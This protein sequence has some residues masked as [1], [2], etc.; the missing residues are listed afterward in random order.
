MAV[1]RQGR[2]PSASAIPALP[3]VLGL[4][5]VVLLTAAWWA[6]RDDGEPGRAATGPASTDRRPSTTRPTGP[7]T[8]RTS[9][10]PATT[11]SPS[12]TARPATTTTTAPAPPP[13]RG[14]VAERAVASWP[15]RRRLAS[16]LF[17]GVD[18]T[19]TADAGR[20]VTQEHVGGLFVG[21]TATGLLTSGSLRDLRRVAPAGLLVA[22]DEE[23]GRVQRIDRLRGDLPAARVLARTRSTAEVRALA[24]QRAKDL[25][26]YG[27]T[28]DFAPSVDT[29]DQP[30]RTVI[31][32]RSFSADPQVAARYGAAF[33]DGL[34]AAG[35]VPTIKHFPGHGRASGDSHETGVVTPPLDRMEPVD[36][37]PYRELIPGLGDRT[38]VMLGHLQVPGLTEPG[39]PASLSPA[40]VDLLRDEY[41]FTGVIVTDDLSGMKAVTGTWTPADAA[42][43]ALAA[44]VDMPLLGDADVPALLDR[45]ERDVRSGAIPEAQVNRAVV[46]VSRLKGVEPCSVRW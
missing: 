19:G 42:S 6:V 13:C 36:L 28:M 26:S 20:L 33:A 5:V 29:S 4:L 23:G 10:A 27:V 40:A 22:V 3:V 32:D 37:V 34:L 16:L 1:G 39:R 46:R 11:A 24:E 18:P 15:L 21:G 45:L 8:T 41:G 9:T 38:A 43:T 12:T 35:V 31:G 7:S 2:G 30:D 25:A 44:G 17:V 14:D